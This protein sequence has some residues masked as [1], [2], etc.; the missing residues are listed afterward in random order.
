MVEN[1]RALPPFCE[2]IKQ[3]FD[4]AY[5]YVIFEKSTGACRPDQYH[6]V[7][8]ILGRLNLRVRGKEFLLNDAREKLLL[9]VQLEPGRT[10]E[11]LQEFLNIGLPEDVVFYAYGN[12]IG[13]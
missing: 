5:S 3:G 2:R 10:D 6:E 9:V 12:R 13:V 8:D 11:I 1:E 4:P 7:V